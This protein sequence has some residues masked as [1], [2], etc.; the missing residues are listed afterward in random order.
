MPQI[1]PAGWTG[2]KSRPSGAINWTDVNFNNWQNSLAGQSSIIGGQTIYWTNSIK[3][4]APVN[5]VYGPNPPN[6]GVSQ[7]PA[8]YVMEFIDYLAADPHAVTAG[9]Y[10]GANFWRADLHGAA[11]W[12]NIKDSTSG[13]FTGIVNNLVMDDFSATKSGLWT[14]IRTF[15][16]GSF[17]GNGS[18]RDTNSFGTNYLIR[19]QGTGTAYVQFNFNVAVVGNYDVYQW[20]AYVNN[21]SAAVPMIVT[22]S[23]GVTTNYA[24][25]QTNAGK[26]SLLGR[27]PFDA[28]TNGV[29]RIT[30]A[31]PESGGIAIADGLKLIFAGA[32]GQ[33]PP[34]APT[35]L[36]AAPISAS[37]IDLVWNDNASSETGFI[38]ARGTNS[39]GP[40]T[41]L[42]N[43]PANTTNYSD[44]ALSPYT[45][46]YY[47]VRAFNASGPSSN[48]AEASATTLPAKPAITAQPQS[49]NAFLGQ[50]VTF[51]VGV[52]GTAPLSYQW[53][54]NNGDIP[55]ATASGYS[56]S[57][58]VAA[59]GGL[60]SVFITNVAGSDLSSN[61]LLTVV[62]IAAAGDNSFGQLDVPPTGL[63]AIA[64][65]AGDWHSLALRPN[66]AVLAWGNNFSGQCSIPASLSNAVA[67]AS[68]GYHGLAITRD[69]KVHAWGANDYGQS[70]VPGNVTNALAIAAGTWHSLALLDDGSVAAW[71]D[72]TS[73][74]TDVPSGLSHVAAIAAHGDHSLA[75]RADGSVV[76]WG[77]NTDADG[78]FAGQ[79]VVP[80]DLTNAL[81]IAA[82]NYH[83]AA[84]R[85]DGVVLC[86]G[87]NSLG[88]SA[89]PPGLLFP[90]MLAGGGYHTI[91]LGANGAPVAWG[92]DYEGQCDVPSGLSSAIAVAAGAHHS[93]ILADHGGFLP[94][95]FG[96][97]RNGNLLK[98]R[99][100]TL[101]RKN[102]ALEFK[103]TLSFSSWTAIA[104]NRGN[105]ALLQF[106][107][108]A[109][110]PTG[111]FYRIRQW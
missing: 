82:A 63:D 66:G 34:P 50:N 85:S 53:R 74:Q 45:T 44:T 5:H 103:D 110:S 10:K 104:T 80:Q 108:P 100:Q 78:F 102:Y 86:W 67:I 72:N 109:S 7:I 31:I 37:R 32:I 35:S 30:D 55:G 29:V 111:R 65:A 97:N 83:S 88:Q 98:V 18:A 48:S 24:N 9:G 21:A 62:A 95:L 64:I 90:A 46:Y 91:A 54:F 19:G 2:V 68:G 71:G 43:L 3:P 57:S 81:L 105:G 84:V 51:T 73:G 60:Y 41:D 94:Q 26:W 87:D 70:S 99:V 8:E 15:Y 92:S 12:A 25:Q 76:A 89:P 56:L 1:Y 52:S 16:N 79:S 96:M 38:L 101:A 27:Y 59:S 20:H 33:P 107:D 17:Y 75:L 93:L 23:G 77:D 49:Q 13:S 11:Q 39:G 58:A 22:H 14:S 61:A 4:L 106:T 42:P 69:G 36:A 6:G 47:V 28:G 40:Y